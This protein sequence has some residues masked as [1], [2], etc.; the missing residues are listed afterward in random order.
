MSVALYALMLLTFRL[1]A[2]VQ[3]FDV[4]RKQRE[5]RKRP[6]SSK[7]TKKERTEAA[8]FREMMYRLAWIAMAVNFV[9]IIVD[10]LTIINVTTRPTVIHPVSV[11][12]MFSYAFGTL[13]LT[14]IIR[15]MYRDALK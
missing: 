11:V 13:I 10:V 5:L 8:E 3:I 12:Y 15:R 1:I 6:I 14:S 7:G 9:P 2:V 4:I